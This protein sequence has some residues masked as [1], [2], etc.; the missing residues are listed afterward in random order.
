MGLSKKTFCYSILMAVLLIFF[1]IIYF[2]LML[3]SLYVNYMEK[4]NLKSVEAVQKHYMKERSYNGVKV[5]NPTGSITAEIP[6]HGSRIYLAGINYRVTVE[7]TDEALK[8]VLSQYQNAVLAADSLENV[9]LP[10]IDKETIKSLKQKLLPE[11]LMDSQNYPLSIDAKVDTGLSEF[12]EK[13]SRIHLITNNLIIFEGGVKDK[14]NDYTSYFAAGKTEDSLIL[15]FLP[16]MTPQITEIKSIV[17]E[18]LSMIM[19]VVFFLVLIASWLFSRKIVNPIIRLSIYAQ[20]ISLGE[21]KEYPPLM[22]QEQDE[23]GA[24]GTA[25]NELY[26][27]LRSQYRTL[28]QENKRQEVFLRASSHQLKTPL[29]AALLLTDGM[30]EEMGKYK[31]T[32]TYLPVLKKQLLTMRKTVEDIL[33]L[34]HCTDHLEYESLYPDQLLGEVL[35]SYEIH[36]EEKHLHISIKGSIPAIN[37]DREILKKI[38]D[39]LISNA[40]FYTPDGNEISIVFYEKEIQIHNAG[41]QIDEVLLPHIF[42]PFVSSDTMQKGRGLGLYVVSYYAG[43]IGVKVSVNNEKAGVLACVLFS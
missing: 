37:S 16:V 1:V 27:R 43:I 29:A 23:I 35:K 40:I 20:D 18:S 5:K 12:K 26:D 17:L 32:R 2:V 4:E 14:M 22:M 42:D 15:S 10:D 21:S 9:T 8:D 24:L 38:M 7:V 11:Q 31:D 25:L 41:A 6:L 3:P 19:A 36:A 30:I 34:N 39:N 33:Y 13:P 28:A